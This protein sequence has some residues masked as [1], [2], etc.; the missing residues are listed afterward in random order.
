ME[1]SLTRPE[2]RARETRREPARTPLAPSVAVVLALQRSAGNAAVNRLLRSPR[3][4]VAHIVAEGE[5]IDQIAAQYG[6]TVDE[7]SEANQDKLRR[8]GDT[9]GFNAGE[10]IGIPR[11]LPPEQAQQPTPLQDEG[12]IVEWALETWDAWFGSRG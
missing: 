12:S 1:H 5:R 8:W 6:V 7:L 4:T 10:E 9:I 3:P 11:P 2:E